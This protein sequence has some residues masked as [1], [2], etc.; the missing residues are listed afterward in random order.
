MKRLLLLGCLLAIRT[1]AQQ[2][3]AT[4]FALGLFTT[5]TIHTLTVTPLGTGAWQQ[6]CS[7]CK[8]IA[9][10]TPLHLDH[11][12]QPIYLDGNLRLQPEDDIPPVEAAGHYTIAPAPD[13]LRVTLDLPSERYVAAVLAAEAAPDEPAASLEA[14]AIAARTYALANLHRHKADGFDLCDSTHCQALRLVPVRPSI[15][16]AVRNTAGI[17]L[18]NGSH[19][20]NIYYTQHCGGTTEDASALWPAEHAPYLTSHADPYCLR[21]APAAWQT[22]IPLADLNRIA[23]DQ[24]WNLPCPIT[25]ARILQHT[26]SG[27]AKLLELAGTS[28]AATITASSLRFAVNRT[29]GWNRIRSDLYTITVA[30]NMLHLEGHGY[31]H[32]VGLCQAGAFQMALEHHTATEILTFY[33]PGTRIGLTASG[34]LWHQETI[35]PITLRT[36]TPDTQL[37]HAVELSWQRALAVLPPSGQTPRPTII[38]APTTELFRQ[39]TI[40][41]GDL[42]AVTRGDQITLQ[43][44]TIL[45][46]SGPIEPL[47]LHELLH[48]LI[49]SQSTPR[50]PLWLREGL[51]EALADNHAASAPSA[52]PLAAVERQL[53]DPS[54]PIAYRQAHRDAGAIVHKLGQT[55]SLTIMRQWLREGVPTQVLETLH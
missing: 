15:S 1:Q 8:H 48:I 18:W 54:T 2:P 34:D 40:G 39:L 45:R 29:L 17:T 28:G 41:T 24:H 49:E 20:A 27:R 36:M 50:A 44:L 7:S 11:I 14:L 38:V 35:G 47:T 26:A 19:R 51:A 12:R 4:T 22:D 3:S 55:Y 21:R 42:L 33:F 37:T 31:G 46:R 16:Q 23:A 25:T 53:T 13:G 43:P 32:A 10:Q 9:L 5:H 6:S 52:S 30:G